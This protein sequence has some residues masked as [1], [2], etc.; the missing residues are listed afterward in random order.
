M[1]RWVGLLLHALQSSLTRSRP[2]DRPEG[3]VVCLHCFNGGCV[4]GEGGGDDAAHDHARKHAKRYNHLA[5]LGIQRVRKAVK[6]RVSGGASLDGKTV[7]NAICATSPQDDAEP[8]M[9]KLQIAPVADEDVYEYRTDLKCFACGPRVAIHPDVKA[10]VPSWREC[11]VLT[12][13][14]VV[15]RFPPAAQA[16]QRG[17]DAID[18]RGPAERGQG[19]GRGNHRVRACAHARARVGDRG[20][21]EW[22]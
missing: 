1:I 17:S 7:S 14:D 10:K 4:S 11:R 2:Q 15:V 19:V 3:I 21:E 8:P 20:G 9:K 6:Q 13:A 5:G 18:G 22:V 12:A 16:P